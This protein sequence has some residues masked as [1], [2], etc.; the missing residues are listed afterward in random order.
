MGYKIKN[1]TLLIASTCVENSFLMPDMVRVVMRPAEPGGTECGRPKNW[2]RNP[3]VW[4]SKKEQ[5][6]L[7]HQGNAQDTGRERLNG[8]SGHEMG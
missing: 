3:W 2:S 7:D 5:A 8:R 6:Q 4:E 1:P